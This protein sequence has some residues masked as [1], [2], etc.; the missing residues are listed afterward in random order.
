M[1]LFEHFLAAFASQ[2]PTAPFP[3]V[4]SMSHFESGALFATT[5]QRVPC[6]SSQNATLKLDRFI[7]L[8]ISIKFHSKS[9]QVHQSSSMFIDDLKN[10]LEIS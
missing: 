3:Q 6:E 1:N 4:A 10:S 8:K 2:A 5:S 9:F 7:K